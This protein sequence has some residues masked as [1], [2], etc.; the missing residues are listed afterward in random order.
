MRAWIEWLGPEVMHETFGPSERIGGTFIT[1]TEWLDH[2]GSVGRPT[3]PGSIRILDAERNELPPGEMGEIFMMPAGGTGSTYDYVGTADRTRHEGWESVGDMGY[4]DE[5]GYLYLGDRRSDM[6]LTGGQNV[7]PAEVEA[8]LQAHP[9]VRTCAVIGLPDEDLGQRVHAI[10]ECEDELDE[11]ALA[12]HLEE[13]L[14]RYKRPRS[15]ERVDCP[16]RDE[17]GKVR[18]NALR[19]ERIQAP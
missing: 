16:L 15:F 5:D 10:I 6:I 18:R 14:V 12:R 11:A 3:T 17:A 1:G 8:A 13:R 7:Y 19:A 9:S 2:P 4:L